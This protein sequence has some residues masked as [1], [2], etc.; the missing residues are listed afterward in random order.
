MVGYSLG[1]VGGIGLCMGYARATPSAGY[2]PI[3]EAIVMGTSDF[4]RY[5]YGLIVF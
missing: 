2:P 1:H 5:A 3:L 4:G